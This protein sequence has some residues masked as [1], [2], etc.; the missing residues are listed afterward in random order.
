MEHLMPLK[1]VNLRYLDMK[2]IQYN[3]FIPFKKTKNVS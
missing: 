1:Y 2:K 3:V